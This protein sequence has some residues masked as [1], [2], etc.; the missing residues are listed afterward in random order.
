MMKN[1]FFRLTEK[2]TGIRKTKEYFVR[3]CVNCYGHSHASSFLMQL[4]VP[5]M[6]DFISRV[7]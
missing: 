3:S 7:L 1:K 2:N 6:K 4:A 5:D